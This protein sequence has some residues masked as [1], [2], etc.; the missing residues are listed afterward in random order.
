V[1]HANVATIYG[2][3]RIGDQIGLWMEFVRGQTLEQVLQQQGTLSV[4]ETIDIGIDLCRALSAVH[5]A[6][7]LHRDV[8]A[9]NVMREADGRVVLMDFG[10]GRDLADNSSSDLTGTPLYLAP[11][12]LEGEP[13]TPKSD[14]YS[15]GVLLY[16]LLTGSYP[17]RAR[18][19]RQVR[20]AHQQ[21]QRLGLHAA[22]PDLPSALER[23][24]D[25]AT[26]PDP[27]RRYESAAAMAADLGVMA[28]R[29]RMRV[30]PFV[31]AAAA[32]AVLA[33]TGVTWR[34]WHPPSQLAVVPFV[35]L[36]PSP[37]DDA[38]TIAFT[39][40]IH[41]SL[42]SVER[43]ELLSFPAGAAPGV[44]FVLSGSLLRSG[45]RSSVQASLTEAATGRKVWGKSFEESS[46]GML[47]TLEEIAD[48]IAGYLGL[49]RRPLPDA[50]HRPSPEVQLA[51]LN[52][53]GHQQLRNTGNA[54]RAAEELQH[55]VEL[56]PDFA[57]A[58]AGI[59]TALS[60]ARRLRFTDRSPPPEPRIR[61]AATR[62]LTLDP[63]L[64]DA[65]AAMGAVYAD[66]QRWSAAE[67]EFELALDLN[68]SFTIT[69]TEYV[70]SV[71][72]PLGRLQQALEVLEAAWLR[73]PL[74]LDVARVKAHVFVELE[75]YAEAIR[76]AKWVLERDATIP[77]TELWIGR[78][79]ALSGK[80]KEAE[81]IFKSDAN[82]WGYLGWVYARTNRRS[83]AEQLIAARPDEPARALLVYGGLEDRD[84]AFEALGRLVDSNPWL[85]ATWMNRP[86]VRTL[87]RGD[88][89]LVNIKQRLNFPAGQ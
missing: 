71:L 51:F 35:N 65:H 70:L 84:R 34:W 53:Y 76:T 40:E 10:A 82:Y 79:H 5:A 86:E 78:S 3:E 85:A 7:L 13:A 37:E 28:R 11:E 61:E 4:A 47:K 36:G 80:Y 58:F 67:T 45:G 39:R 44:D 64:A 21:R 19:L 77:F 87:L 74:S 68:P 29:R 30:R 8:K 25:R 41:R 20:A 55:V 75:R 6:G 23:I 9:T 69:H 46:A 1:R 38:L 66:E 31:A 73:D 50:R 15:L 22:R 89:R 62:A 54:L 16:H 33:V 56:D 26:D 60:E 48:G 57:R 18:T 72:M 49:S 27:V 17:V 83:E 32:I 43:L 24:I 42:E 88:P 52:A 14:V 12:I 63:G 81:E 59:A 2:A